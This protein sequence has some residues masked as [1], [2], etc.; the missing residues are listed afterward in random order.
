MHDDKL[1]LET[2]LS[3]PFLN[4][5]EH[6]QLGVLILDRKGVI[7]YANPIL[8]QIDELPTDEVVGKKMIEFY[9]IEKNRHLTIQVLNTGK[10]FFRKPVVYY[11]H[12]NKLVNSLCSVFPLYKNGRIA[13]VIL[14]ALNM[15]TSHLL[16]EQYLSE[17]AK[18][19]AHPLPTTQGSYTF[20]SLIGEAPQ[21]VSVINNAKAASQTDFN[22]LIHAESGCGKELFSQAIHYASQRKGKPFIPINC[23]AIPENLL[24]ATLFGTSKGAFTGAVDK[25]GLLEAAKG[26]T[27]LLDEL[28]SMPLDLQAKLLRVIQEK[29][30]RRVGANKEIPIDVRFI[31]TCN[32]SPDQA[33]KKNF[34]RED[35]FYR[36]AVIVLKIPPLRMRRDDIRILSDYFLGKVK[37][38]TGNKHLKISEDVLQIF[39]NYR[40]PGNV[41]EMEHTINSSLALLQGNNVLEKQHLSPYFLENLQRFSNEPTQQ[42]SSFH[43]SEG[44]DIIQEK[45]VGSPTL[46]SSPFFEQERGKINLKETMEQVEILYIKKALTRAGYNIS[47]AGRFL[48]LSPQ[49]LRYKIQKLKIEVPE[50]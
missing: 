33:M 25:S 45:A 41:R 19:N 48:D 29:R 15:Q 47:K 43:P 9:P 38:Q 36:L 37:K 20:S 3:A 26:G 44:Q 49:A 13:G 21:F 7:L 6:S 10:P 16:L 30:I 34:I 24:E 40:W 50:E 39:G 23:S 5:W 11:T 27:L 42:T 12:N 14:S 1:E 32:I 17:N 28:N 4:I 35:L 46:P 2:V 31:S 22:I 8:I 18:P